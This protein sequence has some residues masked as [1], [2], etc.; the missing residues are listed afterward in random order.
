M[1]MNM[2]IEMNIIEEFKKPE[3]TS[4]FSGSLCPK[5]STQLLLL[6]LSDSQLLNNVIDGNE[7]KQ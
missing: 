5:Q 6:K 2:N 1:N 4:L 3:N 7:D